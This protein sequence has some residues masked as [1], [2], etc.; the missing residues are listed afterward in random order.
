MLTEEDVK[1]ILH[2]KQAFIE[3][4]INDEDYD[5]DDDEELMNLIDIEILED[6]CNMIDEL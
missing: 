3:S 2:S 1:Q 6:G 4:L 5:L